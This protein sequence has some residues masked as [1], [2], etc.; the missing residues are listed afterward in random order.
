MDGCDMLDIDNYN[1]G[2]IG[3]AAA[4]G[5]FRPGLFNV[6]KTLWKSGNAI[7]TLSSQATNTTNR[8]GKI[9]SRI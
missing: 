3:I 7:K 9:A 5:A 6:G 4:A 1:L 8:A 2:N